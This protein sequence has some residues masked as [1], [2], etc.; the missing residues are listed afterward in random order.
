M[1]YTIKLYIGVITSMYLASICVLLIS[2]MQSVN[3]GKLLN[4]TF[5][6][7]LSAAGAASCLIDIFP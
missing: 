5:L 1:L 7:S 2:L 4:T 3:G 6:P